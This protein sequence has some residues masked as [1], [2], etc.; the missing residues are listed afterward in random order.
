[1]TK[2]D[3]WFTLLVMNIEVMINRNSCGDTRTGKSE[4]KFLDFST[5]NDCEGICPG[6][7]H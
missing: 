7:F 1:M 6:C 5:T 2:Y 4:V 3:L